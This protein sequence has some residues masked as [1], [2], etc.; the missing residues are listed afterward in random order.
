VGVARGLGLDDWRYLSAEEVRREIASPL[1]R[2]AALAPRSGTIHPV[3]LA[4][5]LAAEARRRGVRIF[6]R[7]PVDEIRVGPGGVVARTASGSVR[8]EKTILATNAYS[9]HLLPG[10]ARRFLPLY[11]YVLVSE[12]LAAGE[13]AAIGWEGRQ[14]VTDARAFFN[15]YRQTADGRILF[16]TS[17]AVYYPRNRVDAASDHSPAHYRALEASFRRHFPALASLRFSHAWGGPICSTTRL[18]PFFG[19]SGGRLFYGLG[20]TGHGIGSTRIA[21]KILAHRALGRE[22]PLLDLKMVRRKPFPYPPE[23]LRRMAVGAVTRRLRAVDAGERPAWLL[24]ALEKA[25]LGF[26]S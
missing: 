26:S 17:E 13:R 1:Y 7:T 6:E 10:L 11:D 9:H 21:G 4:E 14:A 25:G 2:G 5:S 15:Y 23:P 3:K 16:G 19:S 12:P 20:Y 22:S 18:T 8:A 24:R